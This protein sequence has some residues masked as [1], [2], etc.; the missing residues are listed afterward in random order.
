ML[1]GLIILTA[2]CSE[3][4][5]H[6]ELLRV[7][8]LPRFPSASAIECSNNLLYVFGDDASW[9][10]VTDTGYTQTDT[11]R[12]LADTA[13]RNASQTK[14]DIEAVTLVSGPQGPELLA[15]GSFANSIRMQLFRF[16]LHNLR[17]FRQL[18][19]RPLL[20]GLGGIATVN[21]EG[22][23]NTGQHLVLANRANNASPVNQL[24]LTP[25]DP[26]Q[27]HTAAPRL[28]LLRLSTKQLAGVS[29]L[30]YDG[31]K[32]RLYFTVSEEETASPLLDGAIG[33]SYLGWIDR[34]T[35]RLSATELV[36]DRLINLAAVDSVF[37]HQKI[38]S[39][40]IQKEKGKREV[41]HLAADNDNG[42]STLF[43]LRLW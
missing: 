12:F 11:V 43:A 26:E 33:D 28:I 2:G 36:P 39:V 4:K 40:C 3:R 6:P 17:R 20:A 19:H 42:Q 21:L 9:L 27:R 16:P 22:L 13:Y 14:A 15:L 24:L 34:F 41:L 7:K 18:D 25:L 5:E 10:L 35:S 30:C 29:G 37:R 32:D 1:A 38:E 23:A 31:E 8:T